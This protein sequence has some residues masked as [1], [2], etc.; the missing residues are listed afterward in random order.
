MAVQT[1]LLIWLGSTFVIAIALI[2]TKHKQ[3]EPPPKEDQWLG[4]LIAT[5]GGLTAIQ[6]L[7]Q[8]I[9]RPDLQKL[10][11]GDGSVALVIGGSCTLWISGKEIYK[12]FLKQKAPGS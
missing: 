6:I 12:L 1:Q 5:F 2:I 7:Y 11:G 10:L 8:A 4:L 3:N 9:A